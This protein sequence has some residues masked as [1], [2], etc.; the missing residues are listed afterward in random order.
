[1]LAFTSH[2]VTPLCKSPGNLRPPARPRTP[3]MALLRLESIFVRWNADTPFS[4]ALQL[5]SCVLIL[6]S[7]L[8]PHQGKAFQITRQ[9]A[10]LT[11]TDSVRLFCTVCAL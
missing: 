3:V 4:P 5:V 8:V 6:V 1:M 11:Q 9:A 10:E 2:P 7:K